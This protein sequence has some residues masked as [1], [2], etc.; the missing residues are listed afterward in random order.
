MRSPANKIVVRPG[1]KIGFADAAEDKEFLDNCFIGNAAIDR[2]TN[3]DDP[4]CIILGRTGAGKSAAL[5]KVKS[6]EENCITLTPSELSLQ[7]V[8]NS[9]IIRFFH[10][11]GVDLDLFFQL[12]WRHVLVIELLNYRYNVQNESDF[13]VVI[14]KLTTFAGLNQSRKL[15]LEYLT[16]WGTQFWQET[17]VRIKEIVEKFESELKAGVGFSEKP[18]SGGI[19]L[20]DTLSSEQKS[21]VV[22]HARNVVNRVQIKKLSDLMDVMAEEIFTDK[23]QKYFILIDQLDEDWV[24]DDLRYRLIRALIETLKAFRKIRNVKI[25]VALRYDLLERTLKETRTPG[26]QREKF[27]DFIIPISWNKDQLIDLIDERI[28]YVYKRQYTSQSVGFFDLFPKRYRNRNNIEDHLIHR[29][30]FRPRDVIAFA[31]TIFEQSANAERVSATNVDDAEKDYSQKRLQALLDEW[32]DEH[33]NLSTCLETLRGLT[34]R[35]SLRDLET[36]SVDD[37]I[38]KLNSHEADD[39]RIRTLAVN[40][41]APNSDEQT[42]DE[43][44]YELVSILYKTGAVGV[45]TLHSPKVMYAY[46]HPYDLDKKTL[47]RDTYLSVSPMLWYALQ[48]AGKRKG[49]IVPPAAK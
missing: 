31:N 29:T 36:A 14:T 16:Q 24:D 19:S 13:K 20:A 37:C 44:L 27:E 15:A 18:L 3:T 42:K 30:Q 28:K 41:L 2:A 46:Q 45:K 12:L 1:I 4:G 10:D 38:L 40:I 11:L 22:H 25:L 47:S 26:F 5:Y 21:E 35:V 39:E 48:I 49:D 9:T 17:E 34:S 43:F 8:S 32:R 33:P 7:F 6:S 23:Q